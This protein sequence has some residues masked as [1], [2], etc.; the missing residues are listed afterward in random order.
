MVQKPFGIFGHIIFFKK[1]FWSRQGTLNKPGENDS[2]QA[3][4]HG[5]GILG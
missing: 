3:I 4:L 2:Y 5:S 1:I